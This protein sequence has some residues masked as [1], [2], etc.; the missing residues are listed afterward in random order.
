MGRRRAA[1]Y[2]SASGFE[3]TNSIFFDGVNDHLESQAPFSV[4]NAVHETHIFSFSFWLKI[5]NPSLNAVQSLFNTAY[6]NSHRGFALSY[7]NRASQPEIQTFKLSVFNGGGGGAISGPNNL[8]N[9]ADWH[10]IVIGC[11]GVTPILVF[12]GVNQSVS[13]GLP[14]TAAGNTNHLMQ[15][16]RTPV[17]GQFRF[18]GYMDEVLFKGAFWNLTT[19]QSIY[20]SGTPKDESSL[21]PDINYRM[22]ES[23]DAM[24]GT[25]ADN[26]NNRVNDISGNNYYAVPNSAMTTA[27]NI[28]ND[29]P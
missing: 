15:I 1:Y 5:N 23:P 7:E 6:S 20:N 14:S 27:A 12:D 17:G 26:A 29:T 8:V 3:S 18:N 25:G 9:N 4:I 2:L 22:G 13:G 24:D 28:S 10:H 21:T 16:G 11:D 19:A